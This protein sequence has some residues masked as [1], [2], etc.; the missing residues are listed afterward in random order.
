MATVELKP[1]S[2]LFNQSFFVPSYQRGYRWSKTH[3]DELLEDLYDFAIDK[4]DNDYY[5]LQP[6]IVKKREDQWELVDGQQRLTA[7]WLISALYYCSNKEDV[8]GIEHQEYKMVYEGKDTFTNLFA[9]IDD[10]IEN[11]SLRKIVE[12]LLPRKEDSIDCEYLINSIEYITIFQRNNKTAKGVLGRIFDVISDIK[13]IWYVLDDEDAIETF[14]NVNANKIELTNAELIKAIILNDIADENQMQNTANRWEEIERGLNESA[15]WN[16]MIDRKR[17]QYL[18]RIDYLFEILCSKNDW[19]DMSGDDSRYKLYRIISQK[20][21]EKE[22][23]AKTIWDDIQDIYDTLR[24]WYNDYFFYH[25]IGLLVIVKKTNEAEII[26]GLYKQYSLHNKSDFRKYLLDELKSIYFSQS[27]SAPFSEFSREKIQSDLGDLQFGEHEKVKNTLLLYNIALLVDAENIYERF[28]FELYK[29]GTWDI[30]HINPQTPREE[31]DD[32]KKA[33]LESYLNL[34]TDVNMKNKINT[35]ISQNMQDFDIVSEEIC[36]IIQ[37]SDNDFIGNLVLL[38][39]ATNRSY[40]NKCFSDKRKVIIDIE[41]NSK[42]EEE[43]YIPIG[44]KWVFLKGYEKAN[45]LI[46]WSTAD[47]N[48]YTADMTTKIYTMLGGVING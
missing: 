47:M 42:K 38:D 40:K 16:Y 30:E 28:P 15:F 12:Q 37:V 10:L 25:I 8:V 24:D 6:V 3:I 27:K 35:C 44:T 29:N 5:C 36:N 22:I 11:T 19:K 1:I 34:I 17:D 7:I 21:K 20:L 18:T 43:K 45:Q 14:T 2:D 41:R 33:W 26:Q 13:V 23:S 4:K 48:E 32:E 39:A 31:S 46:I 9:I